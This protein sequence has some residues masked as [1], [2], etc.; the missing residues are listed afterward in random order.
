MK[1]SQQL[2]KD[3]NITPK[4]RLGQKT[5]KG[6]VSTGPHKVKIVK[7]K[8]DKGSDPQTGKEIEV[9][10]YLVEEKGQFKAYTV[11]KLDRKSGEL[12]YLVQRLAEVPE[13]AE[14]ILEMKKVG[15]KNFVSVTELG[16]TDTIEYDVEE[17]HEQPSEEEIGDAFE[18][19]D[20]ELEAEDDK[21]EK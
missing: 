10:K 18:D 2:L 11:P 19:A 3:A 8:L 1:I 20:V 17:E 15:I 5:N 21:D 9:V 16:Q 13:N 7:D 6:V 14:I 4:L 12:H